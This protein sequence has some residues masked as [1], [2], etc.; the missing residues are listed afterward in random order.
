MTSNLTSPPVVFSPMEPVYALVRQ[1]AF[2]RVSMRLQLE[3]RAKVATFLVKTRVEN[4]FFLI[5]KG[6]QLE[7]LWD[8]IRTDTD[9]VDFVL[10]CAVDLHLRLA[11]SPVPF[12]TLCHR[13]ANAFSCHRGDKGKGENSALDDDLYDRI[14]LADDL[15]KLYLDN[16]WFVFLL[17]LETTDVL[18]L[19]RA[20]LA[21]EG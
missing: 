17:V 7:E 1:I 16:A 3:A 20:Q 5:R 21:E 2:Q 10:E 13:L 6:E 15:K 12:E 4:R 14:G 11:D 18:S 9:M 8:F 19:F